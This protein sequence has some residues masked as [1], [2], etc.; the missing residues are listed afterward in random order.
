MT[1]SVDR[2]QGISGGLAV[3]APV[4]V[5]TTT[6]VTLSGLQ[7]IDSITLVADDRVLVT[8]QSSSVNNGIYVA[9]TGTWTRSYDFNGSNDAVLG[10][11]VT[12]VSG[13]NYGGSTWAV[14]A[15]G[16]I[17]T[18]ALTFEAS[19][20]LTS[21]ALTAS[22]SIIGYLFDDTTSMADPGTGEF[23]L[24]HATIAS[25]TAIAFSYQMTKL[26]LL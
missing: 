6:S 7:T 18:D 3:K 15:I 10:T 13:V 11:L 21:D 20:A 23:R 19:E 1:V 8:G 4:R 16:T 14:S 26:I 5:A 12:V 9:A 24:N 25:A 22:S 17:G 2:I